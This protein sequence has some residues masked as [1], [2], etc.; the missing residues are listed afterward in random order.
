[1]AN[2][3]LTKEELKW[4]TDEGF[5]HN[6]DTYCNIWKKCHDKLEYIECSK[7]LKKLNELQEQM[8]QIKKSIKKKTHGWGIK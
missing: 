5:D 6:D 3:Y 8:D 2:V 1:M 7:E 4:L